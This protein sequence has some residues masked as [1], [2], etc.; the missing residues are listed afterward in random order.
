MFLYGGISPGQGDVWAYDTAANSWARLAGERNS[1]AGGPG[2]R[3]GAS[4]LPLHVSP[5]RYGF[6]L[7]GGRI[8]DD[9]AAEKMDPA[10]W[11]FDVP[12]RQWR[13]LQTVAAAA[14]GPFTADAPPARIYQSATHMLL[15]GDGSGV[16]AATAPASGGGQWF[17]GFIS[18]G[19]LT[20]PS[21]TCAADSWAFT[22]DCDVTTVSWTRL[23]DLPFGV[24]DHSLVAH[25]ADG[26]LFA[27][28][29]HLCT[30]SMGSMPFYYTNAVTMLDASALLAPGAVAAAAAE[31]RACAS[32]QPAAV[33][34]AAAAAEQNVEPHADL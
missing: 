27:F 29:G 30:Q 25:T 32:L 14:E 31:G 16:A 6:L 12:S 10:L 13:K 18:G 28:G 2:R 17:V 9:P 23:P 20:T 34:A 7:Y 24:Y 26:A 22:V 21:L 11:F 8:Y 4:L 1:A 5:S 15:P 3:I 19:T 33:N